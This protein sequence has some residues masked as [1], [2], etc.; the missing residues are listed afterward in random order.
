LGILYREGIY[1]PQDVLKAEEYF[2]KAVALNDSRAM[3]KLAQLYIDQPVQNKTRKNNEQVKTLLESAIALNNTEAVIELAEL[4]TRGGGGVHR[5]RDRAI[6]LLMPQ[7]KDNNSTAL[8]RLGR[9]YSGID[10]YIY[11]APNEAQQYYEKAVKLGHRDA[12]V[13]LATLL[14]SN[15]GDWEIN[16]VPVVA[17]WQK[18]AKLGDSSALKYLGNIYQFKGIYTKYGNFMR[19]PTTNPNPDLVKAKENYEKA[20]T[21]G[22]TEAMLSLGKLYEK[23]NVHSTAAKLYAEAYKLGNVY[24]ESSLLEMSVPGKAEAAYQLALIKDSSSFSIFSSSKETQLINALLEMQPLE[25]VIK[26]LQQCWEKEFILS[27]KALVVLQAIQEKAS[28]IKAKNP[29]NFL[30]ATIYLAEGNISE[31]EKYLD[32]IENKGIGLSGDQLHEIGQNYLNLFKSPEKAQPFLEAAIEAGVKGAE[33]DLEMLKKNDDET[34]QVEPNM[35]EG[36]EST[37]STGSNPLSQLKESLIQLRRL[38]P[39]MVRVERCELMDHVLSN[40]LITL[41]KHVNSKGDSLQNHTKEFDLSAQLQNILDIYDCCSKSEMSEKTRSIFD[42]LLNLVSDKNSKEVGIPAILR[43]MRELTELLGKQE[44]KINQFNN[45]LSEQNQNEAYSLPFFSKPDA[46][47]PL[48]HIVGNVNLFAYEKL[49]RLEKV[50]SSENC[51]SIP[52]RISQQLRA[53]LLEIIR[54]QEEKA[55]D[56]YA[57][58]S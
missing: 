20:V 33:I 17:L 26:R 58:Q 12:M 48:N 8:Y 46:F 42:T 44:A 47:E 5:D 1:F 36:D 37:A 43:A 31:A 34:A 3:V 10:G 2:K 4:Y 41:A 18:A 13:E 53:Q 15:K 52:L 38:L 23:Q 55:A 54:N 9:L 50:L 22:N 19:V 57:F 49:Q 11:S 28:N 30:F 35:K 7:A 39:K 24:A 14:M 45:L 16:W 56:S 25:T 51:S 32:K 27:D 40:F 21:L 6:A 29:I